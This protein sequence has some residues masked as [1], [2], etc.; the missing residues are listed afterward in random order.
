[1]KSRVLVVGHAAI[2]YLSMGDSSWQSMGGSAV[3]TGLTLAKLGFNAE[4]ATK[5]GLDFPDEWVTFLERN[6]LQLKK[7]SRSL[8][9]PTTRFRIT[10]DSSGRAL[11]L[12]S[13]CSDLDLDQLESGGFDAAVVSPLAG[14]VSYEFLNAVSKMNAFLYVD[15]QG[16]LRRFDSAGRCMIAREEPSKLNCADVI[17]VDLEEGWALTS[18]RE[19]LGILRSLLKAEFGTVIVTEGSKGVHVADEEGRHHLPFRHSVNV[20]DSTGVGDIFA[21][22]FV[23]EYL[24][25]RDKAASLCMAAGASRIA[26]GKRGLEKIPS[27]DEVERE[28]KMLSG[29]LVSLSWQR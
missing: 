15:P 27:K 8:T 19:P 12:L 26:L 2:D 20:L 9:H 18:S 16:F 24:K 1:M 17:K 25:T 10:F 4:I 3:Y 21:G 11:T 7:G 13:R 6:G 5:I 23:A 22:A 28:S 29:D 14:E